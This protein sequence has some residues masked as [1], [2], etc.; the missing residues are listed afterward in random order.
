MH[1]LS[2]SAGPPEWDLFNAEAAA[3]PREPRLL[4]NS[5]SRLTLFNASV[6]QFEQVRGVTL[7]TLV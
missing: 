5:H 7:R 1:I 6:A 4:V 2:G 3:W